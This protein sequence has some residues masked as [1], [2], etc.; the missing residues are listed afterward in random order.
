MRFGGKVKDSQALYAGGECAR[1]GR[2]CA[3]WSRR[4]LGGMGHA[5]HL[6]HVDNRA[7]G[8]GHLGRG[9]GHFRLLDGLSCNHADDE[10]ACESEDDYQDQGGDKLRKRLDLA[11]LFDEVANHT[12]QLAGPDAAAA[13][14]VGGLE[15]L[16]DFHLEGRDIAV[17]IGIGV[18]RGDVELSPRRHFLCLRLDLDL[19]DLHLRRHHGCVG[20][21]AARGQKVVCA[22]LCGP[23]RRVCRRCGCP[24]MGYRAWVID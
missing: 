9:P 15:G 3:V 16:V 18:E 12:V 2:V 11:L 5:A 19:S 7:V 14:N 8:G 24:N 6:A 23:S 10:Y 20:E 22:L 13:I 1:W 4:L 21:R 17:A